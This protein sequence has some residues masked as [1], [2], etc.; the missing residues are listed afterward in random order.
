MACGKAFAITLIFTAATI[1]GSAIATV[2]FTN[3]LINPTT[4]PILFDPAWSAVLV[5]NHVTDQMDTCSNCT[6]I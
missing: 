4:S 2:S 3:Y 5:S 6:K 1:V